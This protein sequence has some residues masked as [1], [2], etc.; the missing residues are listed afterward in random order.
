MCVV[1]LFKKSILSFY[2]TSFYKALLDSALNFCSI[3]L[4]N[5]HGLKELKETNIIPH[6]ILFLQMDTYVSKNSKKDQS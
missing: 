5:D 2:F 3:F 6:L 4:K 1:K